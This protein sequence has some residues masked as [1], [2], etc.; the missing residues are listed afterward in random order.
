MKTKKG[1]KDSPVKKQK[2]EMNKDGVTLQ[3][4][5]AE[6]MEAQSIDKVRNI[7]FGAQA[8]QYEQKFSHLEALVQKEIANLRD[9]NKKMFDALEKYIKKELES[10]TDQLDTEKDERTE[11]VDELAGVLKDTN[12][13]L[14]KKVAKLDEKNVKGQRDLQDQILQQSK[15]L[16][17]EIRSKHEEIFASL[18]QSVSELNKDKTDRVALANLLMEVSMR[19][20][21]EF[22]IPDIE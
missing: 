1:K 8:R 3:P 19:L 17:A 11:A 14:E 13:H 21:E 22:D 20:K 15:D 9:E 7:L 2:G 12:K 4:A 10:L 16:M 6:D 5:D 18:K